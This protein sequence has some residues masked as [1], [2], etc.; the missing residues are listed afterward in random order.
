MILTDT[1]LDEQ[2]V[3]DEKL[4]KEWEKTHNNTK[5][6]PDDSLE[7]DGEITF[8][9][10]KVL[11]DQEGGGMTDSDDES[12]IMGS[13][14]DISQTFPTKPQIMFHSPPPNVPVPFTG[15][16]DMRFDIPLHEL[17]NLSPSFTA[18]FS[19]YTSPNQQNQED[20]GKESDEE[21]LRNPTP[22]TP[23]PPSSSSSKKH[24]KKKKKKSKI[25]SIHPESPMVDN[26]SKLEEEEDEAQQNNRQGRKEVTLLDVAEEISVKHFLRLIVSDVGGQD[27]WNTV[28]VTLFRQTPHDLGMLESV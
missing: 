23:P 9:K 8:R 28:E 16:L 27:Y 1:E 21:I 11:E 14:T 7:D 17:P 3:K 20:Q 2:V 24:K 4:I 6:I 19:N 5:I 26:L 13:F 25:G 18:S 22:T 15:D 10:N 12:T